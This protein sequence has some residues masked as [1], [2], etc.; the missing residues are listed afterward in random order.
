VIARVGLNTLPL[1]LQRRKPCTRVTSR[2]IAINPCIRL[3]HSPVN[4]YG[5]ASK[6]AVLHATR[7][8]FWDRHE[9]TAGHYAK[10]A[11]DATANDDATANAARARGALAMKQVC[12]F[13]CEDQGG[14]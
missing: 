13:G 3:S 7:H 14:S 5:D 9:L 11:A 8:P 1:E 4:R 2:V 6:C 12:R 10:A